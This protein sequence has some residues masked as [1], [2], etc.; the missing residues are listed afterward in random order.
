ML[1][2]EREEN[3]RRDVV[4]QIRRDLE[5]LIFHEGADVRLQDVTGHDAQMIV[6]GE[7]LGEDG[8]QLLVKFDGG[9][10]CAGFEKPLRQ[11]A[12]A[13]AD[14]QDAVAFFNFRRRHDVLD[15]RAVDEEVLPEPLRGAKTESLQNMARDG[16]AG[17]LGSDHNAPP[18]AAAFGSSFRT[19][20]VSAPPSAFRTAA[21]SVPS[22]NDASAASN[23]SRVTP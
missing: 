1:L 7:R 15:D 16:G 14:L 17:N 6:G 12:D 20:V 11:R 23:S 19:A 18:F 4:G 5:R 13:R 3:R 22:S 21:V 9:D 10:V 8:G 2:K